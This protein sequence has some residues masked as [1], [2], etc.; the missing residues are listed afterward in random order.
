[1]IV[2]EDVPYTKEEVK[3]MVNTIH[4]LREQLKQ[5]GWH[6]ASELPPINEIGESQTIIAYDLNGYAFS[7]F[8]SQKR[9]WCDDP[10]YRSLRNGLLAIKKQLDYKQLNIY[11][12][13]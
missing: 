10:Y 7:A 13:D 11:N 8:Y 3:A 2:Q 5:L 6:P 4:D 1:M 9:G 12:Y